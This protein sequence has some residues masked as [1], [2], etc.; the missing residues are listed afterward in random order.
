MPGGL[1]LGLPG[2]GMDDWIYLGS[3]V[4]FIGSS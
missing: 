1:D 3:I 2:E 4:F